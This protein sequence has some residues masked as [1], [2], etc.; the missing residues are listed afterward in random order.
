MYT[1]APLEMGRRE[2]L[3]YFRIHDQD[4]RLID[5]V[6]IFLLI[7]T[8]GKRFSLSRLSSPFDLI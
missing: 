6:L 8:I 3:S 1:K 5:A 4:E 7:G 2:V